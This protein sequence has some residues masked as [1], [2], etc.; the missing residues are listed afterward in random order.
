MNYILNIRDWRKLNEDVESLESTAAAD[1]TP[2]ELKTAVSTV[3]GLIKR[4]FTKIEAIALAGNMSVESRFN[5][6][7]SDGKAVGLCQWQGTRLK[8]LKAFAA[9]KGKSHTDFETQLNFIKYEMK[10]YYL[11]YINGVPKLLVYINSGTTDKPKYIKTL[12]EYP[13]S[14]SISRDFKNAVAAGT[15]V[16]SLTREICNR[17]LAPLASSSHIER[18]V[19]NALKIQ[20]AVG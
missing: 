1:I 17:V 12:K 14:Q 15:T 5:T 6:A 2:A 16:S 19:A 11:D 8:A 20:S 9:A 18:R 13:K 10:D 3:N 7:A 4:G